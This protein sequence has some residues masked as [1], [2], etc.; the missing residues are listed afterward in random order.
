V[1]CYQMSYF[2]NIIMCL[3]LPPGK[4][5]PLIHVLLGKSVGIADNCWQGE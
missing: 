1:I 5:V 4:A 2:E 3:V